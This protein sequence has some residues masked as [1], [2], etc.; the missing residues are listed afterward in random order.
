MQFV[1]KA[2]KRDW[3]GATGW[4]G[5]AGRNGLRAIGTREQAQVFISRDEAARAIETLSPHFAASGLRFSIEPVEH[6]LQLDSP[7]EAVS[8]RWSGIA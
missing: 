7:A 1:V 5:S 6:A 8:K 2:S 3:I 4:I